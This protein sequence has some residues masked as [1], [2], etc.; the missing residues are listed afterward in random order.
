MKIRFILL[1]LSLLAPVV[2]RAKLEALQRAWPALLQV[3][4]P[5]GT[6]VGWSRVRPAPGAAH[7]AESRWWA[8]EAS[9]SVVT[10]DAGVQ[11]GRF[12]EEVGSAPRL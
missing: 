4:L 10:G 9:Q 6:R 1:C 7:L 11:W 12:H 5:P 3:E 2:L 8:N